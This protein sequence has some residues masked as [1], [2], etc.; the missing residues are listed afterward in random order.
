MGRPWFHAQ[1]QDEQ[2][3]CQNRKEN[4]IA[5]LIHA[6]GFYRFFVES[7]SSF[8]SRYLHGEVTAFR[9]LRVALDPHFFKMEIFQVTRQELSQQWLSKTTK[10][11]D[12]LH[13]GEA[14]DGTRNGSRRGTCG[15]SPAA[16]SW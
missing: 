3:G 4:P 13:G 16:A 14:P 10:H 6:E 1:Q 9:A 5:C 7:G 11:F 2:G 12:G 15:S 8:C